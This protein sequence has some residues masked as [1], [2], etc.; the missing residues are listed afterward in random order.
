MSETTDNFNFDTVCL[1][2][3]KTTRKGNKTQQ[4]QKDHKNIQGEATER[5]N[6]EENI[7]CLFELSASLKLSFVFIN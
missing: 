2:Q 4:Q 6:V 1:R 5:G 3:K 7:F